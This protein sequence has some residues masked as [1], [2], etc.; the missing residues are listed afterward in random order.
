[1]KMVVGVWDFLSQI[2]HPFFV[3]PLFCRFNFLAVVST[4][5]K[6]LPNSNSMQL[7]S[8]IWGNQVAFVHIKFY[9]NPW[10][11]STDEI[12]IYKLLFSSN[13]LSFHAHATNENIANELRTIEIPCMQ[14]SVG[15]FPPSSIKLM[16]FAHCK[17]NET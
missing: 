5:H 8:Q 6:L 10:E 16:I 9:W 3:D 17:Y 7:N 1:M 2:N 13:S 14:H 15:F 11:N 12:E 4:H